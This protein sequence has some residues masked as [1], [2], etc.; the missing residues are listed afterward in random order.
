[1]TRPWD[2]DPN[3]PEHRI[4]VTIEL[5]ALRGDSF[6]LSFESI[7]ETPGQI[8]SI[9]RVMHPGEKLTISDEGRPYQP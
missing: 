7:G 1:M 5:T 6:L 3:D 9:Q 4:A 2:P 8:H